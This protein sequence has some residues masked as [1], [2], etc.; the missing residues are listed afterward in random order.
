MGRRVLVLLCAATIMAGCASAPSAVPGTEPAPGSRKLISRPPAAGPTTTTT[1]P[2]PTDVEATGTCI[3]TTTDSYDRPYADT[4]PWNVPVCNLAEDSRSADWTNRFWLY[5]RINE[6][7]ADDP[8][9]SGQRDLHEVMFGL[10]SDPSDDFSFAVY[11][12]RDATTTARVF[13][14]AGWPGTFNVPTATSI[15]WN[16]TW[17]S[18]TGSDG[19]LVI[20]DPRTGAEWSIW[21]LAQSLYGLPVNDTQCW[22][23][24][25]SVGLP[26]G[27]FRPGVDLCMGGIDRVTVAGGST[28]ADYRTYGGNNPGTRGVGI[29]RYAMTVTPQEVA[30]GQIR[31]ALGMIVYNTMTGG[32]VCTE[33]QAATT[34]FGST[35][36]QAVAPAGQFERAS[37]DKKGCNEAVT[38][39]MSSVDYRKT[40]LPSGMRFALRMTAADIDRWLDSRHYTGPKR[41]TARAFATALVN[42]GWFITDTSCGAA[43]F[44]TSGGA[45]PQ[46]AALWRSLGITGDG[47]DLLAGLITK[48][49]IWTVAP[50]TNHCADGRD[51]K[52]ACPARSSTYS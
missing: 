5:S 8:T 32:S 48:D 23:D 36:G 35:C 50:P 39:Q 6:H 2:D 17:R 21:G 42:Y 11:D 1:A 51:S 19:S 43:N 37:S 40:T 9:L 15:P 44:Q 13:R 10:D 41:A 49:R 33:A 25:L 46:T 4:A 16:P 24:I 45:N 20:L 38:Q 3:P 27:G 52:L 28:L 22:G 14:R 18:S 31:H 30:T 34:A 29:D 12:A 7:M 47:R 26:G